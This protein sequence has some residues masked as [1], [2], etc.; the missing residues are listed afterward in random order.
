MKGNFL[1]LLFVVSTIGYA[2]ANEKNYRFVKYTD[3]EGL[4]SQQITCIKQDTSGFIWVGTNDGLNKFDGYTFKVYRP[5][6]TDANSLAGNIVHFLEMDNK[7]RLWVGTNMGLAMYNPVMDHFNYHILRFAS[8]GCTAFMHDDKGNFWV[9]LQGDGIHIYDS[10]YR[11]KM[12]LNPENGFDWLKSLRINDINQDKQGVIWL[13]TSQGLY[14]YDPGNEAHELLPIKG[15]SGEPAEVLSTY[16]DSRDILWLSTSQG[17]YYLESGRSWLQKANLG[18][19]AVS[20]GQKTVHQVIEDE[21]GMIWI[22][23]GDG[24]LARY[25]PKNQSVK[26][27]KHNNQQDAGIADGV[28]QFIEYDHQGNIW[29]GGLNTNLNLLQKDFY[30]FSVVRKSTDTDNTI[31]GNA[32]NCFTHD[33]LG[34]IW[35]ATNG[36]GIDLWQKNTMSFT[37]VNPLADESDSLMNNP[38]ISA[39]YTD[40]YGRVWC[41]GNGIGVGYFDNNNTYYPVVLDTGE[42]QSSGIY[43]V[44]GFIEDNEG[45][46]WY[47]TYGAGLFQI[48]PFSMQV[49]NNYK[50]EDNEVN[51]K[52]IS[53]YGLQI[54]CD[55]Q[56]RIW[57][58]TLNGLSIYDP[59]LNRFTNYQFT[60]DDANSIPGK[61]VNAFCETN[62]G[63]M[64]IGTDGGLSRFN[65]LSD[66][67][68]S[69]TY[70]DGLPNNIIRGILE[71]DDGQLWIST[72]AGLSQ[73]NPVAKTFKNYS[74]KDGLAG[75]EF[76]PGAAIKISGNELLFGGLNG[77]TFFNSS[78]TGSNPYYPKV[79]LTA[80]KLSNREVNYGSSKYLNK[81]VQYQERIKLPYRENVITIDYVG[82]NY[83][84]PEGTMYRYK[85]E[86]FDKKWQEAGNKRSATYTNLGPGKYTFQ[87]IAGNKDGV[88]NNTGASVQFK[89]RPPWYRSTVFYLFIAITIAGLLYAFYKYRER[90][91]QR[92]KLNLEQQIRKGEQEL[93]KQKATLAEQQE[94]LK[95]R[96]EEEKEMRFIAQGIAKF[97]DII[98]TYQNDLDALGQ[99]T[100][101]ELVDYVDG[102]MGVIYMLNTEDEQN[103]YLELKGTYAADKKQIE[104]HQ[105]QIGEG[106]VGA[107]FQDGEIIIP[108]AI[109][110]D[111]MAM[112]SGLGEGKVSELYLIPIKQNE[113]VEGVIEIGSFKKIEDYKLRFVEKIAENITS[114]IT[115]T[116]S[117]DKAQLMLDRSNQQAEEL[118]AQ[119][120][121][122][123]QNLEEMQATQDELQRKMDENERMQHDLKKEKALLDAML[124]N[125]PDNIYFKDLECKFIRVSKSM[126]QA[127]GVN[128][129]QELI[130]KSD[131]DFHDQESA[132]IKF[133]EE[134]KIIQSE[135]GVYDLIEHDVLDESGIDVWV[136][137]TKLPFYNKDG[138]VIGTFGISRDVTRLKTAEIN[139]LKNAE[140]MQQQEEELRQ[141]LEEMQ[142][143]QEEL[144]HRM[145]MNKKIQE[146]LNYEKA[147]LD[148]ILEHLPDNIYFKDINSKFLRVS[149]SMLKTKGI[150]KY[151]DI[152]GKSD[153]DFH[154]KEAAQKKYSEEQKIIKTKKGVINLVEHDV[155]SA[156]EEKWVSTTKLPFYDKDGKVIGTFG[157]SKDITEFKK[158]KS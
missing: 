50:A 9:A 152:I 38:V 113:T 48:D 65:P 33:S 36:G 6:R 148:A 70:R 44:R 131:F 1:L 126:M 74:K 139:A 79:Y 141:N 35:I 40:S 34:H 81:F 100:I 128:N 19:N 64:W 49:V 23:C 28:H 157:I 121:E 41:G 124:D 92:D 43:D 57:I 137:T 98:S 130:G 105:Y 116:K 95:K 114:V 110:D 90:M 78:N 88:W 30:N 32:I 22:P 60:P 68:I 136:S 7:G 67:F 51:N 37:H 15:E 12:V 75:N 4:S 71:A 101:T 87:V 89:I 138:N 69:Y 29:V 76:M 66:Q 120:E 117:A 56:G 156:G 123:R 86:G 129:M 107:C 149:K 154:D 150:N 140:A 119:E 25:N 24:K 16:S 147:L 91:V 111:Y 47:I 145:E 80:F 104:N 58:G 10:A 5:V 142:T 146:K 59:K 73:F 11:Q 133:D 134:Q 112:E 125:L 97:S 127:K 155:V 82:I 151:E 96:D 84:Q 55:N 85:M 61:M 42:T 39:L 106:Y 144:H 93:E 46:M 118:R 103:K 102:N 53:N 83:V 72:S 31:R 94:E 26:L 63:T 2:F 109:P 27:I 45:I 18:I 153:F 143:T 8:A 77:I 122:L 54:H 99:K 20:K 62:D 158:N 21:N 132:Q 3:E 17:L 115:I 52:L 13:S 135:E 108:D 14:K